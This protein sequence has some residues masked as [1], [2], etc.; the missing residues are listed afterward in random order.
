MFVEFFASPLLA[1]RIF[2]VGGAV[3]IF[4]AALASAAW[5]VAALLDR[6][7]EMCA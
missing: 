2:A 3:F 6:A 4:A 1:R 7:V 5:S